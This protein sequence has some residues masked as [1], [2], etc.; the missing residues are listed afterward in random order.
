MEAEPPAYRRLPR[1]LL[2]LAPLAEA[3][4]LI[5]IRFGRYGP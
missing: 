5:P 3:G 1:S 4:P 2:P